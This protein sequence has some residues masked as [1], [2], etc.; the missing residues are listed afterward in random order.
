MVYGVAFCPEVWKDDLDELGFA[1]VFWLA[2]RGWLW[3][4][5]EYSAD[6]KTLSHEKRTGLLDIL[7]GH[8][9]HMG[10]SVRVLW[11]VV[12]VPSADVQGNI[13]APVPRQY[14]AGC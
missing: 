1:G 7:S 11:C 12:V 2:N 13:E 4:V 14:R 10:W 8:S 3:D 6:S 9:E 5:D